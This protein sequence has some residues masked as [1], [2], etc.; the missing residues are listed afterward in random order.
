MCSHI[1]SSAAATRVDRENAGDEECIRN[2]PRKPARSERD[3][4]GLESECIERPA[5]R[6]SNI[7]L[8]RRRDNR[9]A[10]F[11]RD[12]ELELRGDEEKGGEQEENEPQ[13]GEINATATARPLDSEFQTPAELHEKEPTYGLKCSGTPETHTSFSIVVNA[14]YI[15][16]YC[17]I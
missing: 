3:D 11:V 13:R 16:L 2:L 1:E 15:Y 4:E 5:P 12:V 9:T 7:Q 10:L 6:E 8:I 17:N 14:L